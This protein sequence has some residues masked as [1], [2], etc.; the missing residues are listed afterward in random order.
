MIYYVDFLKEIRDMRFNFNQEDMWL[1]GL[2]IVIYIIGILA[3]TEY[4][5]TRRR[6]IYL[7][8]EDSDDDDEYTIEYFVIP[9]TDNSF[10][11]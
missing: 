11:A 5:C 4:M 3:I 8:Q 2:Y 9:S 7:Q 6:N 1:Y 10:E